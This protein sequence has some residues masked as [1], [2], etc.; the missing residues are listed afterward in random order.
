[1]KRSR[2]LRLFFLVVPLVPA[3]GTAEERGSFD[4]TLDVLADVSLEVETGSGSIRIV[5]G[6]DGSVSIRGDIRAG[7]WMSLGSSAREKVRRI[8]ENPPIEQNG[9]Q[10]RIGAE[11][12]EDLYRNVSISYEI[13][14]PAATSVVSRTGSGSQIIGD[15][16]GPVEAKTGSGSIR[17][18]AVGAA[19]EA[20]SGS[21]RIEVV[22]ARGRLDAR[23]GSGAISADAVD[24]PIEARSGS[25]SIEIH[26]T[27]AGDVEAQS[28]S[29]S[30]RLSG[31]R[32]GLR[33]E[34]GSGSIRVDGVL[35]GNWYLDASSGRITVDL[36]DDASFDIDARARSGSIDL[37][38]PVT[39]SGRL[40]KKH[41]RGKVRDGGYLLE[42]ESG[43]GSIDVR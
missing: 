33:A 26:Q 29:G 36:P 5:P 8:E 14:V 42:I 22:S 19:V 11:R 23:T 37:E 10:I 18:G 39:I 35:G 16:R 24:G 1:M 15:V 6:P 40:S 31:V 30:I 34:A 20:T 41:V 2:V 17:V 43:S 9:G 21:G 28:G 4:R 25:G 3:L 12:D 27:G 7:S 13:V 32:G 38:H